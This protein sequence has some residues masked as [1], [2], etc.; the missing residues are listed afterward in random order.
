MRFAEIVSWLGGLF[1]LGCLDY[2]CADI[3]DIEAGLAAGVILTIV[4]MVL[5]NFALACRGPIL[6]PCLIVFL[7]LGLLTPQA[8]KA[9]LFISYV[10]FSALV[11]LCIIL[12]AYIGKAAGKKFSLKNYNRTIWMLPI[13][14]AVGLSM[15]LWPE[16]LQSRLLLITD[17]TL[18][19][20]L[21]VAF[22]VILP[23][24]IG[25]FSGQENKSQENEEVTFGA[26]QKGIN[27]SDLL[28]RC[29][30]IRF[31]GQL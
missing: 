26:E 22:S 15:Y 9:V 2:I 20:G 19:L 3:G 23:I 12:L 18:Q 5:K 17:Q 29:P 25:R 13:S 1:L 28:S 30:E 10:Q 4:I 21:F 7:L 11:I 27:F 16:G 24:Y 8:D 6:I 31:G 14:C